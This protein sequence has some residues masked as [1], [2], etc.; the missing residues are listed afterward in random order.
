MPVDQRRDGEISIQ[1]IH[2]EVI[3]GVLGLDEESVREGAI[4]YPKDAQQAARDL[5]SG[6]GVLALYLNALSPDEVFGVTAAGELLP[7]KSTFF[8]PKLPTGLLFRLMATSP[9][10][11]R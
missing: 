2:R 9:E 10:K 4:A 7:Q 1:V 11:G 5:R 8:L 3:G 6:R